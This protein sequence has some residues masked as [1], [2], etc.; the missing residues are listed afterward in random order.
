MSKTMVVVNPCS[1]NGKTLKKWPHIQQELNAAGAVFDY[2]MTEYS[3]HAV[4]ITREALKQGY[5][6]IVAVGG[7]GTLNEVV[8]GFFEDDKTINPEAKLGVISCGTGGDFVRTA[9]LAKD[10]KTA[11]QTIAKGGTRIIDIGRA[12]FKDHQ[13]NYMTKYFINVAGFGI[14][15]EIVYRVNHTSKAFGGFL[16]FLWGTLTAIASFQPRE[17]RLEIDGTIRFNGKATVI[18][19]GNGK[20]IGGGMKIVPMAEL[21][22]G[23]F[24]V[25]VVDNMSKVELIKNLPRIYGG[26][27]IDDP[28]VYCMRGTRIKA[29]SPELVLVD[30]EGEQPGTLDIDISILP[31]IMRLIV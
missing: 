6:T 3:L 24:D 12:L 16:S 31:G 15:G 25:I 14:D 13:G 1:A 5:D 20:Y 28:R 17:I 4:E 10:I 22:S 7:D 29:S 9:G 30:I 19:A 2:R 11:C 8:N 23:Y 26:S 18:A 27:H 21:D